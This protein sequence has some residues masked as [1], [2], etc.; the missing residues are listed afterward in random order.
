M[1]PGGQALSYLKWTPLKGRK[2]ANMRMASNVL[3]LFSNF[4]QI[5]LDI[6]AQI[7]IVKP[8][9]DGRDVPKKCIC[10]LTATSFTM[11]WLVMLWQMAWVFLDPSG[12]RDV[13]I[14]WF[15][16]NESWL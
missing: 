16:H 6:I 11:S 2:G 10:H 15:C 9:L 5:L 7:L 13:V 12:P 14:T 8:F 1:Q 4:F 3:I